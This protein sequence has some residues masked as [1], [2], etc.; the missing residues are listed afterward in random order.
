MN[1]FVGKEVARQVSENVYQGTS[2]AQLPA[3]YQIDKSFAN[4]GEFKGDNGVYMYALMPTADNTSVPSNTRILGMR[5][6]EGKATDVYADI[7]DVGHGQF[8]AAKPAVNAWLANNIK[9]GNNI[10]VT[11][12]SLG[13]ALVQWT[14]NDKNL[15][16]IADIPMPPSKQG[17]PMADIQSHLH[18]TT[19][20]A[21]GISKVPGT[22]PQDRTSG[23]SGEHHVI[24]FEKKPGAML[25]SGDPV[26]LLGGEH[27]GG[28]MVAHSPNYAGQSFIEE[29]VAHSIVNKSGNWNAPV[30][31]HY[32]APAIDASEYQA[33]VKTMMGAL[34]QDGQPKSESQAAAKAALAIYLAGGKLGYETIKSGVN[35]VVDYSDKAINYASQTVKL[36]V[37]T[38]ADAGG[39]AYEASAHAVKSGVNTVV[40]YSQKAASAT[41]QTVKL[42]VNTVADAGGKAYE[43]SAHAVKSGAHALVDYG[44]KA[45]NATTQTIK[46]GGHVVADTGAKAYHAMAEG[47]VKAYKVLEDTAKSGAHAAVDYGSKA[48]NAT[49]HAVKAGTNIVLDAGSASLD[50]MAKLG[51]EGRAML[52]RSAMDLGLLSAPSTPS[53]RMV[54]RASPPPSEAAN[55]RVKP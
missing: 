45:V 54:E 11:G 55:H 15:Q 14:V 28:T 34:G 24:A 44:S 5:G 41:I 22:T 10:E 3:G 23:I 8:G 16:A 47:G 2:G 21:P 38:V 32:K 17:L 50:K 19:F 1:G 52:S 9:A 48:V 39:K 29:H 7:A 13:G 26:H 31:P 4:K 42:G 53:S 51:M 37:N 18:F 36:G 49:A 20:N 27:V 6:T 30:L 43:A 33:Y 40:D 35:T 25:Y 46:Y 12:H